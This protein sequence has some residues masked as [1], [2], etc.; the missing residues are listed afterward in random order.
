MI[1]LETKRV[2]TFKTKTRYSLWFQKIGTKHSLFSIFFKTRTQDYF[3]IK[4]PN[5]GF[6]FLDNISRN[7]FD[8]DFFK[9]SLLS[10]QKLFQSLFIPYSFQSLN[11][12]VLAI[13]HFSPLELWDFTFKEFANGIDENLILYKWK[14]LTTIEVWCNCK[15]NQTRKIF[16]YFSNC[17]WTMISIWTIFITQ[18]FQ[19]ENV[20]KWLYNPFLLQPKG[21]R[22][23]HFPKFY[24]SFMNEMDER[25]YIASRQ[26][27]QVGLAR[28][29]F[30]GRRGLNGNP[31]KFPKGELDILNEERD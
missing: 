7:D 10:F 11:D 13:H 15:S 22:L 19:V 23:D 26:L 29:N 31:T 18:Y 28:S 25:K 16:F 30:L 4:P 2:A 9:T 17:I 21:P 14:G 8:M 6:V 3:I 20:M 5:I 24:F 27:F 1:Q 12:V